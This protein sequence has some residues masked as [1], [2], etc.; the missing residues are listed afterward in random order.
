[1]LANL[2]HHSRLR[3]A[4]L[5]IHLHRDS[6]SDYGRACGLRLSWE[7]GFRLQSQLPITETRNTP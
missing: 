4:V 3:K 1:M 7:M 5:D 2:L 6:H